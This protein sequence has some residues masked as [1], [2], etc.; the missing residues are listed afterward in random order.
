MGVKEMEGKKEIDKLKKEVAAEKESADKEKDLARRDEEKA[1]EAREVAEQN[2]SKENEE[3]ADKA[4]EAALVVEDRAAKLKAKEAAAK[5]KE[6]A[7]ERSLT[8][9]A[10]TGGSTGATESP[11]SRLLRVMSQASTGPS[12]NLAEKFLKQAETASTGLS[13]MSGA[14]GPGTGST[15]STGSASGIQGTG[16]TGIDGDPEVLAAKAKVEDGKKKLVE[17]EKSLDRELPSADREKLELEKEALNRSVVEEEAE[18]NVTKARRK[19]RVGEEKLRK[20]KDA[21]RNE[22]NPVKKKLLQKIAARQQNETDIAEAESKKSEAEDALRKLTAAT[23]GVSKK[24]L[25][26]Q[27]VLVKNASDALNKTVTEEKPRVL[28]LDAGKVE[29]SVLHPDA[30]GP[31][32]SVE[33]PKHYH[34]REMAEMIINDTVKIRKDDSPSVPK[35]APRPVPKA[36]VIPCVGCEKVKVT[37]RKAKA[38]LAKSTNNAVQQMHD[39]TRHAMQAV[40]EMFASAETG[41]EMSEETGAESG[42]EN[43]PRDILGESLTGS[44]S[45]TTGAASGTTGAAGPSSLDIALEKATKT[46]RGALRRAAGHNILDNLNA[47]AEL[48]AGNAETEL[49]MVLQNEKQERESEALKTRKHLVKNL[50]AMKKIQQQKAAAWKGKVAAAT[51][52]ANTVAESDAR[53][54]QQIDMANK[55]LTFVREKGQIVGVEDEKIIEKLTAR[56]KNASKVLI[57]AIAVENKTALQYLP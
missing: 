48:D 39:V 38:A 43:S 33:I 37:T 44:A 9:V 19:A 29:I 55:T 8:C 14:T 23:G 17:L 2:P 53:L 28:D 57:D 21:A 15:G 25:Q 24:M 35:A 6:D 41:G 31:K 30:G 3:A 51:T 50:L 11:L 42:A 27:L 49:R 18:V 40:G 7:F 22:S 36:K 1:E 52:V 5:S 10:T 16:S 32:S 47:A 12:A 56:E 4:E 13:G 26:E 54:K 34:K 45:G 46:S 20:L